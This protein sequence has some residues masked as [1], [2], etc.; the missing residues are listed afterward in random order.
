MNPGSAA[1]DIG[2]YAEIRG[3]V[4]AGLL[5]RAVE[6]MVAEVPAFRVRFDDRTEPVTQLIAPPTAVPLRRRE[7]AG[8][9]EAR[10]WIHR[11]LAVP[12]D[13]TRDPMVEI[14][15]LGLGDDRH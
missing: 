2:G 5:Q 11:E 8:R 6:A 14:A 4:D 15:L 10:A 3:P 13:P 9:A 7:F 12:R 1:Y